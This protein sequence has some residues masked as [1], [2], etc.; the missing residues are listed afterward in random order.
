[1]NTFIKKQQLGFSFGGFLVVLV[2]FVFV[3]LFAFKLIPAYMENAKV[4]NIF[5]VISHD[6]DMQSASLSDIRMSFDK[7]AAVDGVNSIK[8]TDIEITKDDAAHIVLN[9]SNEVKIKL[10]GN[11]TL[12]LE[13]NPSSEGK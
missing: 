10:F 5:Y 9:A 2:L 4:Q 1:M 3:T 11:M 8:A 7:R 6:P 13:F 12:L